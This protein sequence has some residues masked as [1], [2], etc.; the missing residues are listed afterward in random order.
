MMLIILDFPEF[1][2]ICLNI[3]PPVETNKLMETDSCTLL[4]LS[5]QYTMVYILIWKMMQHICFQDA[6]SK[7]LLNISKIF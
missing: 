1:E 5:D 6:P 2:D 3:M 4:T 7:H